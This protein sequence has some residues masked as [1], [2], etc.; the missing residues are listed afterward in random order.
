MILLQLFELDSAKNIAS[1]GRKA[2]DDEEK[3]NA[4]RLLAKKNFNAV[5]FSSDVHEMAVDVS[6]TF[7]SSLLI[8]Y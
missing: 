1:D 2:L 5:Q 8:F 6:L 4:V 3:L 7:L